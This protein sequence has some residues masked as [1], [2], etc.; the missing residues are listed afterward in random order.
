MIESQKKRGRSPVDIKRY[1]TLQTMRQQAQYEQCYSIPV[2]DIF[3]FQAEPFVRSYPA[4]DWMSRYR[5]SGSLR[6]HFY[7]VSLA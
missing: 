7:T 4:P 6:Y 3:R 1:D 5:K 2:P